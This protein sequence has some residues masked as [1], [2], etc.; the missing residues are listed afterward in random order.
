MGSS[1]PVIDPSARDDYHQKVM[2]AI[3]A[4]RRADS[5][6]GR[7]FDSG[8]AYAVFPAVGKCGLIVGGAHG[9]GELFEQGM[10]TGRTSLT[11]VTVGLQFGGQVYREVIFFDDPA[12]LASFKK[13]HFAL[14]AQVS[15]VAAAEGAAANAKY[16]DGVLVFTLAKGGLMLEAS[17][18][19]QKFSFKPTH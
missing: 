6:I 18:G 4:F 9:N 16:R 1:A 14:S 3:A 2:E 17:V 19:G 7:I 15:A 11:Q 8:R 5:T 10:V 13:G 12:A